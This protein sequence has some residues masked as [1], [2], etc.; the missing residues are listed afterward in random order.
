MWTTF[1]HRYSAAIRD[2]DHDHVHGANLGVRGDALLRA[3]NWPA[4]VASEDRQ[5]LHR[6]R[7][8]GGAVD[9]DP[10]LVVRTSAR[11]TGRGPK[12]FARDPRDLVAVVSA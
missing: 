4:V 12:G 5:L 8:N 7:A 2:R 3:G 11:T 6:V 10:G 1:R 9:A